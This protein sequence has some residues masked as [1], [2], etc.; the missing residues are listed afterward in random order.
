MVLSE[1]GEVLRVAFAEDIPRV[2]TYVD[3][4]NK[5][6]FCGAYIQTILN[7]AYYRNYD[8]QLDYNDI[9]NTSRIYPLITNGFYNASLPG[10]VYTEQVKGMQ[11]SY[12]QE[13]VKKCVMIPLE[14]E[15]PKYYYI[16]WPFDCYI[17]IV[18]CLS[19][20]AFSVLFRYMSSNPL[21]RYTLSIANKLPDS[22]AVLLHSPN[23]RLPSKYESMRATIL[24]LLLILF[25]FVLHNFYDA[26]LHTYNLKPVFQ[27]RID[28]IDDLLHGNIKILLP[29][30]TL[31]DI[32]GNEMYEKLKSILL[33]VYRPEFYAKINSLNRSFGYLVGGDRWSYVQMQQNALKKPYFYYSDICL[34]TAF[35]AFPVQQ[36][37]RFLES[38]DLFIMLIN[39]SG[40]W[41]KWHRHAILIA[42]RKKYAAV[43]LDSYPVNPLELNYFNIAWMIWCVGILLS[44]T[45]FSIERLQN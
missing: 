22:I 2:F 17:W 8:I 33:V 4:G 28:N 6:Y 16:V 20:L 5:T 9:Y 18:W 3:Y 34:D 24:Y 40:L 11:F 7:F 36:N 44:L 30:D 12:P 45:I 27:K 37:A 38:F 25:G 35:K 39:Q 21:K 31:E 13:F 29:P 14:D 23:M 19:I 32:Q 15:I 41:M 43:L 1:N 10:S 42:L 26:Y